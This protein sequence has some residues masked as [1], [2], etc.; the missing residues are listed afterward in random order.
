MPGRDGAGCGQSED[1]EGGQ[2]QETAAS[3]RFRKMPWA[4]GS[5]RRLWSR[6]WSD[7]RWVSAGAGVGNQGRG[8]GG[9][10]AHP[11]PTL[12][13]SDRLQLPSEERVRF[14]APPVQNCCPSPGRPS[15]SAAHSFHV[16]RS[17]STSGNVLWRESLAQRLGVLKQIIKPKSFIKQE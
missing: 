7:G 6:Q 17:G 12:H 5:H 16:P 1:G 11:P 10:G 9:R 15:P 13:S 14:Q 4:L 8:V 2:A 3:Y